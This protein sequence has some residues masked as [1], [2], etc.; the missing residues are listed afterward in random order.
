MKQRILTLLLGVLALCIGKTGAYATVPYVVIN[1]T[2]DVMTFY[3][4]DLISTHTWIGDGDKEIVREL[5]MNSNSC[6][7]FSMDVHPYALHVKEVV[8]DAS[9]ASQRPTNMAGW[10]HGMVLL[11]K[12]TNLQNLNTSQVTDMSGLFSGCIRLT[13]VDLSVWNVSKVQKLDR[14]FYECEKLETVN[15]TGWNTASLTSAKEMFEDCDKLTSVSMYGWTN[16]VMKDFSYMFQDCSTV[17]SLDLRNFRTP[18]ATN[19]KGMF[20]NCS[21]LTNLNI[22]YFNTS[23]VTDM[24]FMFAY[25]SGLTELSY[26]STWNTSKVT[27]M[28]HMFQGCT[29]LTSFPLTSYNTAAL[30]D[31]SYMFAGCSNLTGLSYGSNWNT[32]KL[33]DMSYA[34]RNCTSMGTGDLSA[35]ENNSLTTVKGLFEGCTNLQSLSMSGNWVPGNLANL[36]D[37]SYLFSG[38]TSLTTVDLSY[39]DTR[40]VQ[41][42]SCLFLGC[43]S[44][45]SV[46][47]LP[48]RNVT[49]VTNM[50][51]LF[52]GCSK[53]AAVYLNG[54]QT[55][56]LTDMSGMFSG[57]SKLQTVNIDQISTSRVTNMSSLF[58]NCSS[59]S[60][61]NVTRWNTGNVLNMSAMFAGCT[62]MSN[63]TTIQGWNTSKVTDMGAL[64]SGC[65][66]LVSL[67]LSSWD[68][69]KVKN[70]GRMFDG[71]TKLVS[72]N[73]ADWDVSSVSS[74][75][76]MFEDCTALD[77]IDVSRWNT[78]RVTNLNRMFLGCTK[79]RTIDGIGGWNTGEVT[80]TERMFEDCMYLP[81]LDLSGW[82]TSKLTYTIEMFKNCRNL[83]MLTLTGWDTSKVTDMEHMFENCLK[84][85]T[86]NVSD[87][88][89]V[90][91]VSVF[92]EIFVNCGNLVGGKGTVFDAAHI[93]KTYARIDGG[94]Y[95]PGYLTKKGADNYAVFNPS[96]ATLTFY[97]DGFK[98]AHSEGTVFTVFEDTNSPE[99]ASISHYVQHV[100]FDETFATVRPK[101]TSSWFY[102]MY[103]LLD[104][105]CTQYLNTSQVTSMQH[106]FGYCQKL[107]ELDLTT[108]NTSKVT[109]MSSMFRNCVALQSIYVGGDWSTAK[110]AYSGMMFSNCRSLVGAANTA[111]DSNHTDASYAHIDQLGSPG[112]LSDI[113]Q[114]GTYASYDPETGTLTFRRDGHRSAYGIYVYELS[115]ADG[116]PTWYAIRKLVN[117]VEFDVTFDDVRPVTCYSWFR[118]M[119]NLTEVSGV[120]Y[121]HT[122]NVHSMNGM[123]QDCRL[124]PTVDLT[125]LNTAQVD[126]MGDMF[127]GCAKLT[128]LDLT[129]F[130]TSNVTNMEN[131]FNGCTQLQTI[132]VAAGWDTGAVTVSDNMFGGCTNLVGGNGTV[133]N[134]AHTD[135][136][137]AVISGGTSVPSYLT[138]LLPLE[139]YAVFNDATA[140]LTFYYDAFRGVHDR[141]ESTMGLPEYGVDPMW[142]ANSANVQHVVFEPTFANARPTNTYHWFFGMGNLQNIRGLQYLNTADVVLTTGMFY[143]CSKLTE[144]DLGSFTTGKVTNMNGMFTNCSALTTIYVGRG[145][146]TASVTDAN[147]MFA[148]C[149]NLVG[150][151]GTTWGQSYIGVER[152]CVDGQDGKK[153]YLSYLPYAYISYQ[154]TSDGV[155]KT[156]LNFAYDG[157][158]G[159]RAL[160]TSVFRLNKGTEEPEWASM[161]GEINDVSFDYTFQKVKPT[162]MCFWFKGM[163]KLEQFSSYNL[164]TSEVTNMNGVFSGCINLKS[165]SSSGWD[166]GK[167]MLMNAMFMNCTSLTS[168]DLNAFTT[169]NVRTMDSMFRN[170]KAL[171]T[172]SL[173]TFNT[174]NLTNTYYMFYA[175]TSLESISVGDGW[176]TDNVTN[177]I[178]MFS[179]CTRL[180]GEKGTTY[181]SSNPADKT[182]AHI[183]GG[184]SSP[185]YFSYLM[186]SPY[187]AW[188]EDTKTL[189]FYYDRWRTA[190]EETFSF[191]ATVPEWLSKDPVHVVF[192]PTFDVA[193][194]TSTYR[195]FY[196]MNKMTDITG[197]EY[198]HTDM[199]T[200][201]NLMFAN[202]T[203][204]HLLDLTSFNTSQVT[205]MSNMFSGSSNLVTIYVGEGWNTDNVTS[206]SS[207]FY[208]CQN[209]KGGWS[210][211][212]KSTNPHD[213]TYAKV[214]GGIYDP[215]Y[216]SYKDRPYAV[217]TE[218][219]STLTI[220]YDGDYHLETTGTIYD[221]SLTGE[222]LPGWLER[223]ADVVHVRSLVGNAPIKSTHMWF[224]NMTN[225]KDFVGPGGFSSSVHVEDMS[226]MFYNCSGMKKFNFVEEGSDGYTI[227]VADATNLSHMF[228]GCSSLEAMDLS[229]FQTDKATDMSGMFEGCSSLKE[230]DLSTFTTGQVTD[231]RDMFKGCSQLQTVYVRSNW[232]TAN[233]FS[234][235]STGMFSGCTQ[236]IGENGTT[237]DAG[238]TDK[239]YA[240][241]DKPSV[242]MPGYFTK[243]LEGYAIMAN[244]NDS[245]LT[246][247]CD[248]QRFLR[249]ELTFSLPE[250]WW[251]VDPDWGWFKPNITRVVFDES[252]A[253]ARPTSTSSWFQSMSNLT[254]IV[255]MENLCTD[256]VKYMDWMFA[257][258]TKLTHIDVSKWNTGNVERMQGVFKGCSA[259]TH[260]DMDNWDTKN[261]DTMDE[262]FYGCTG[263][264]SFNLGTWN[265]SKLYS[266]YSMFRDCIGLTELDLSAWTPDNLD[267]FDYMFSGCTNLMTIYA[268]NNWYRDDMTANSTFDGCVSLEGGK[269]TV[270]TGYETSGARYARLDGGSSNPGFFT[271]S[272]DREQYVCFMAADS[273]LLFCNDVR[274][275][276][277]QAHGGIIFTNVLN[278]VNSYPGWHDYSESVAHVVICPSF[279]LARPKSLYSC[280]RDMVNLKD[281]K[282]LQYL[283]TSEAT[284]MRYM[285]YNCKLLTELDVS[286]FSTENVTNMGSM[287]YG[288]SALTALDV[289][290][291][292]TSK[293]TYMGNLFYGCSSLTALD[294]SGWNTS[295]VTSLTSVFFNCTSLT[296]LDVSGWNTSKATTMSALFY[297]C[298]AL[299]KID[300][301]GWNTSNVTSMQ[302]MF[303]YCMN[304]DT[305]DVSGFATDKV[306]NMGSMFRNCKSLKNLDL[307]SFNTANVTNMAQMF[308]LCDSLRSIKL[309]PSH[310]STAKVT[311]MTFM[312]CYCKQLQSIDVSGFSTAKVID[313]HDMFAGCESLTELDLGNFNTEKVTKMS[314]MFQNCR[315]LKRLN[316]S[317]FN[318]SN[319]TTMYYMFASCPSLTELDVS[320]FNTANVTD[321]RFMFYN[322]SKLTALDLS[323]FSTAN[324]SAMD[325]M[326]YF[327]SQ[328]KTIFVGPDWN[329]GAV[330]TSADMFGSNIYLVG[331]SGTAYAAAN[332]KDKTYA[333]VDGGTSNPGYFTL[334]P[335]REAY[336]CFVAADSTL[337]FH[338]DVMR[339]LR[340]STAGMTT[341][342]VLNTS[343]S[344]PQWVTDHGATTAHVVF[345]P[346]FANA[347]PT[348]TVSW[349]AS[350]SQLT[351]IVG[352]R[353]LNTDE[354]FNMSSMFDNCKKLTS[355]DVSHFNTEKVVNLSYM[356]RNCTMLESLDLSNFHTPKLANL[357]WMFYGCSKLKS[358]DLSSFNTS[359]VQY[360]QYLFS[361]CSSLERVNLSGWNTGKVT[362]TSR[363]FYGCSNL[364][365]VDLSGFN[366]EIVTSMEGM[367]GNCSRLETIDVSS[368]RT[369]NVTTV[370]NMFLGCSSVTTI[371]G[372]G[373]WQKDGLTSTDMF[374]GCTNLVGGA[375]TVFDAEHTDAAYAHVDATGNPGYFTSDGTFLIGDVN[376]D[377]QVTI[378]DVTALVNII[379]G[380]VA[381]GQYNPTV[382]DVNG[383]TQITIADVTKLVNIIL[384]KN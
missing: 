265:V 299:E 109:N 125:H 241:L 215:G 176:N 44:L 149:T 232:S 84:L 158:H 116:N 164:N 17:T 163:I 233:V 169:D 329:T 294:V 238:H 306:T 282:G 14:L 317:S 78:G 322:S 19:M 87:K 1:S 311:D 231:M 148:G 63:F 141:T 292:N 34:F 209:L 114:F 144:I 189:T 29:G 83:Q 159:E 273:T 252:F 302:S 383:D 184:S 206:S 196:Y 286:G 318:T 330:T 339:S 298:K 358:L 259:L 332:P 122:D 172:L 382:A 126:D 145:W 230:L 289:S 197:L 127:N 242:G 320:N 236:L 314:Y 260:L 229:L 381:E 102:Q 156:I 205:D 48:S 138:D 79:L 6:P 291:W 98:G 297:N 157:Y 182:Y 300:V 207:M 129:S 326:F 96:T 257:D 110:V 121:L 16:T 352:L 30:T 178:N 183:D 85:T 119:N 8:F 21:S 132:V 57:C 82:N 56:S 177:S 223:S 124:L 284:D 200:T 136:A 211:T 296:T 64:F 201:M 309:D 347:R 142:S 66:Q 249:Q 123:F 380:K 154:Y 324:V 372:N 356:F 75:N 367:F 20:Q 228:A 287:F 325:R 113:T 245:T 139:A 237:F 36:T 295:M 128:T 93:D 378:A 162:T 271:S 27:T 59:L 357:L 290:G 35:Y 323:S 217:F 210:T 25:C 161:A 213:K 301:S 151:A 364:K 112:Y 22:T 328:L 68:I 327:A 366:T 268:S 45:T 220:H 315:N 319:V 376:G 94:T 351:D 368:F 133:F 108:W 54:L 47:N 371:Y 131:M 288:C 115:E 18:A 340:N 95:S 369:T 272:A 363:M 26:G 258:C 375:G 28:S 267:S 137:Y 11:T 24:S 261:V 195:W 50:S 221:Y 345:T 255:G 212:Y 365:Q 202:C 31:M 171:K 168:I 130:S 175:C 77:N 193:R 343:V 181:K 165:F 354:V 199:V 49:N 58:G 97:S 43:S 71:C 227:S 362:S 283:N 173:N 279:A 336:A 117:K 243:M 38:C 293:V 204:L 65:T 73:L 305:L 106:M 107:T 256:S 170:C 377:G 234:N 344:T 152:A 308:Y 167:V 88:W 235:T 72:L 219:D 42:M 307:E 174:P 4:D 52:R 250:G 208:N 10:F 384:G 70:L 143:G 185:G 90:A 147:G 37:M 350:M 15:L 341:Y 203:S 313:M 312:F 86:I 270:Y 316:V 214:D 262:L 280:F 74:L 275:A 5:D 155:R 310:F 373:N 263:I 186:A 281:V 3:Y 135:K 277:R 103:E 81:T 248:D 194:P 218:A 191:D 337:T 7:W 180:K 274:K 51:G 359:S 91:K 13:N 285:F 89:N 80:S 374:A 55:Y 254:E 39:W 60:N 179:V 41:N 331:G 32:S 101:N 353:Y 99:W 192:D 276:S 224:A 53:L 264:T 62:S 140:T 92:N 2:T 61:L 239:E 247:V 105:K 226:Y 118:G 334:A 253:K 348:R 346:A 338:Y 120:Q 160:T 361:G 187:V 69:S 360:L 269:G 225:L 278:T 303:Y 304:V 222:T 190:H 23:K 342:D 244:E 198:L 12:L 33:Q 266:S 100:V 379:L 40:N 349:F 166:T 9:F 150:A 111:Y 333:H 216:L 67:N 251:A 355:I 46:S 370:Q 335:D 321:M 188:D 146:T 76:G 153:G 246:F 240:R 134:A 104:V